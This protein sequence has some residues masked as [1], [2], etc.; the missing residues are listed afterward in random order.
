[1]APAEIPKILGRQLFLNFIVNVFAARHPDYGH[2]YSEQSKIFL[3]NAFSGA[4]EVCLKTGEARIWTAGQLYDFCQQNDMFYHLL[5]VPIER[6]YRDLV[7][8]TFWHYKNIITE[9]LDQ[10][11]IDF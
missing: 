8:P 1:M 3:W 7:L 6:E 4:R 10:F 9:M 2:M 5:F 11:E